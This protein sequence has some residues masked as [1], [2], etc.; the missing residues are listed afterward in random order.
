MMTSDIQS[1]VPTVEIHSTGYYNH[2]FLPDLEVLWSGSVS[3]R[4]EVYFRGYSDC[5]LL[6]RKIE[7]LKMSSG[8]IYL[9]SFPRDRLSASFL[10]AIQVSSDTLV[11]E[12]GALSTLAAH[13]TLGQTCVASA[14]VAVGHGLLRVSDAQKLAESLSRTEPVLTWSIVR[15][16]LGAYAP[17]D[18]NVRW[19][20]SGSTESGQLETVRQTQ[21]LRICELRT[22]VPAVG[23][24]RSGHRQLSIP[25]RPRVCSS[26]VRF[27]HNAA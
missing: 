1:A 2:S 24:L 25:P 17:V 10:D 27:D 18:P 14:M 4:R 20:P 21:H 23:S 15:G 26:V 16:A 5:D 9:S 13:L 19:P 6:A 8:I 3:W 12:R 11:V 7:S 22:T